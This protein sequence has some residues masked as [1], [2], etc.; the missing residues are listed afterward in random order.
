MPSTLGLTAE[1]LEQGAKPWPGIR[2]A[3]DE[4]TRTHT[5]THTHTHGHTDTRTHT[6]TGNAGSLELINA[7]RLFLSALHPALSDSAGPGSGRRVIDL[8]RPRATKPLQGFLWKRHPEVSLCGPGGL[9]EL[10]PERGF[11]GQAHVG[12]PEWL[13]APSLNILARGR[14]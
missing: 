3:R 12:H 1:T 8:Q 13:L 5:H 9:E 6:H 14:G 4:E 2:A 7:K 10:Q 11:L